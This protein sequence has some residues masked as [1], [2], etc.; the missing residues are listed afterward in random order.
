MKK[1]YIVALAAIFS[2]ALSW[3]AAAQQ[4]QGAKSQPQQKKQNQPHAI[5]NQQDLKGKK[6]I[7]PQG[8]EIGTVKDLVKGPQGETEYAVIQKK[9]D[10][11][12][13]DVNQMRVPIA[14]LSQGNNQNEL[15]LSGIT[16]NQ[17]QTS[18]Y[19]GQQQQA[20]QGQGNQPQGNQ[21]QGADIK[22]QQPAPQVTVNPP[23]PQIQV[24]QPQPQVTV[25]QAQPQVEVVQ[26]PPEIQVTQPKPQVHVTVPKPEV[27]VQQQQP[28]VQVEQ[29]RPD[30]QV[31]QQKPQVN[32]QQSK[33]QV[34]VQQQG[35]PDVN[36]QKQGQA[37]ID[38]R[39][40]GQP[41]L[42]TGSQNQTLASQVA[43]DQTSNWQGKKLMSKNGEELGTVQDVKTAKGK[44]N[45]IMVKGQSNTIHPVPADQV[46]VQNQQLQASFD[47][48]TFSQSPGIKANAQG[49]EQQ[50]GQQVR[51]YYSN[52]SQQQ[53]QG[54]N[55][56]SQ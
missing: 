28:Q 3:P 48:Q 39:K 21:Q 22:V 20:N 35:Q 26:P 13:N 38:I 2:I 37:Q 19:Y 41:Q 29:P 25:K 53:Q 54:K 46:S 10:V 36:I 52:Q 5:Q 42:N 18:T 24:K 49:N 33:P 17:G 45:Y 15:I 11:G 9:G 12:L 32:V 44:V 51:S 55:S 8:E 7:G 34:N 47:K 27:Q 56:N 50:W 40:Q 31:Q 6:V 43:P 14:A 16:Q 30:V 23:A 1:I 4:Q